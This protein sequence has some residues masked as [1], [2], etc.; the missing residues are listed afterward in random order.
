MALSILLPAPQ[1]AFNLS[2]AAVLLAA[3]A[4]GVMSYVWWRQEVGKAK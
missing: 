4:P 2:I 3:L 1:T